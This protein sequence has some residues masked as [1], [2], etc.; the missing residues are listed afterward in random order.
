MNGPVASHGLLIALVDAGYGLPQQIYADGYY[1][2][3]NWA[4]YSN[5]TQLITA[6]GNFHHIAIVRNGATIT[7]Y[8]DGVQFTGTVLLSI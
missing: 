7:G 6:D 2:A 3:S 5:T 8:L 4:V 1:G